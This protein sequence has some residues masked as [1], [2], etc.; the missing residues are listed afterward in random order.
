VNVDKAVAKGK[1]EKRDKLLAGFRTK[2]DKEVGKSLTAD[3]AA[4]FGNLSYL[5]LEEEGIFF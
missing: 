3:D 4:L 2:L 5:M 1:L